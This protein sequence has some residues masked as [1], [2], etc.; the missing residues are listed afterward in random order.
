MEAR[1]AGS[2][3]RR[4][5][6]QAAFRGA[7]IVAAEDEGCSVNCGGMRRHRQGRCCRRLWFVEVMATQCVGRGGGDPMREV[8]GGEHKHAGVR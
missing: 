4:V 6:V 7:K 1:P 5:R 3:R 2:A 8:K